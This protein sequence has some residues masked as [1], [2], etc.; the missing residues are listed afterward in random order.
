MFGMIDTILKLLDK[1][2][3]RFLPDPA[4]RDELKAEISKSLSEG[5]GEIAKAARD[6]MVADGANDDAY[7][8][9][10]RPTVVYWSVSFITAIAGLGSVEMA[11]PLLNTL[12][13]VPKELW[14]VM[15][16]GIGAYVLA[17]SGEK[18]ADT[19]WGKR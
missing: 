1:A 15:Y 12:N 3:E 10:A 2:L 19:V 6:V 13:Q 5:A 16:V 14:D 8:R 7:T 9:R 17:R 18:I 4:Q 11:G